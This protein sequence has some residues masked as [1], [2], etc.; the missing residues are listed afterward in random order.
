M[1]GKLNHYDFE[2]KNHRYVADCLG[3]ESY[4]FRG[5]Y[6]YSQDGIIVE[7]E[8]GD[9]VIDGGA[10][11][12]DT[13]LVFSNAVGESG[14][15]YSFD[16]VKEHLEIMAYNI[17]Q[18]PNKNV[19]A[20][21]VGLSNK[22]VIAEPIILGGYRPG[23]NSGSQQVPLRSID[24]LVNSGQIEKVDFIK[25]DVEGAEMD[26]L[27]GAQQSI[28]R[29]KPKL[30]ISLYHKPDDLFEIILHIKEKIPFYSCYVDHYTIHSE[31]TVL[32]C[33]A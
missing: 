27:C 7:P 31:E 13:A 17:A 4:L 26:T 3:F 15:V 24:S 18:F 12:G 8:T 14:H 28:E 20:M 9:Y 2:Y 29:F 16:P 11:T 22:D 33:V 30:A 21:P 10:C 1:F 25:L 32:Y 19:Q 6:F 23:F 5:Q